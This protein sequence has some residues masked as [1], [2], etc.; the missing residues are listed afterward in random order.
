MERRRTLKTAIL[1]YSAPPVVGGVEAVIQ[2]HAGVFVCQNLPVTVIAG[3]GGPQGLPAS[4]SWLQLPLLDSQHEEILA[5]T[6]ALNQG[7]VPQAFEPLVARLQAELAP[8]LQP[9]DNVIIHNI[10]SK[11]FNLP[12]T[13]ALARLIESGDLRNPIAWCHD[14]TWSSP[15]SRHQVHDGFPWDLLRTRLAGVQYVVV[16]KQ[17]QREWAEISGEPAESA[18]VIYNGVDLAELLGL[19]EEA[20]E[21][22]EQ[23]GVLEAGLM[24]IM[25]VRVT[26]AKNIEFAL[27]TVRALKDLALE[28]CLLLTGPP[29]PHNPDSLEYFESLRALRRTL[30]LEQEFRFVYELNPQGEGRT[31]PIRVVYDLLRTADLLLMPSHREGFGMPVLEAGLAGVPVVARGDIPAAAEVA[32]G[33]LAVR[34]DESHSPEQAAESIAAR[35]ESDTTLRLRRKVRLEYTWGNLFDRRIRPLLAERGNS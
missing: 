23:V 19:G 22:A 18:R 33:D 3:Q 13:V 7:V 16:S 17:R 2:A 10:F 35:L 27:Q 24:L 6:A 1:H 11:H 21:L 26:R 15:N 30:E 20:A 9:F 31:I 12:L 25:P 32:S 28:P 8:A 5:V 4:G 14:F 29:D 34:L